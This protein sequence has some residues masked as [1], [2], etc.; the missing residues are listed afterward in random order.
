MAHPMSSLRQTAFNASLT[1]WVCAYQPILNSR[2]SPPDQKEK[3][4][5]TLHFRGK[6]S[7]RWWQSKGVLLRGGR[8][9]GGGTFLSQKE[10]GI[11]DVTMSSTRS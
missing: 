4:H 7:H 2:V 9:G 6:R 5:S 3:K 8:W 1:F 10:R 11:A